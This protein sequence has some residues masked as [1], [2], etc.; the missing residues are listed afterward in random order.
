MPLFLAPQP[1]EVGAA[2]GRIAAAAAL[3]RPSDAAAAV[4]V[5][6]VGTGTG[7]LVPHLLAAG[8]THVLGCDVSAAMVAAAERA[9]PPP[10]LC[11]NERGARFRR[12]DV[13]DLPAYEG[14]FDAAFFNAVF[15]NVHDQ[16]EALFRAALLLRPGGCVVVSHPLGAAYVAQLHAE[17]PSIVPHTL[18]D[19]RGWAA[20][21]QG[22]PL[23]LEALRD[24]AAFYCAT[25]RLP[26]RLALPDG[27]RRLRARVLRG[28]GRGSRQMGV[29]TA[30]MD[31]DELG[32]QLQGA[33]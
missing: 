31:T 9:H 30:N 23:R 17:E 16:R 18:P 27:P 28:F 4:R 33:P 21:L 25:L 3:P 6:D 24:E 8:A 10:G 20:L 32:A 13:A 14:P 15:A 29:P 12:G 22:L 11:G 2:L 1:A 26:P 5:L 19:A 7:A